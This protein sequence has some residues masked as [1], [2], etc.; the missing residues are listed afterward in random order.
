MGGHP[1]PVPPIYQPEIPAD[2]IVRA[3]LDGR[4]AKIV[5]SWN[6]LLMAAGQ[7]MTGLS[8]FSNQAPACN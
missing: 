5:G 7:V 6:K 2:W 1:Q 8:R 3:A 4:R